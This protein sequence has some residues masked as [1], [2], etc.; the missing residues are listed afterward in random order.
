MIRL[1]YQ[2]LKRSLTILKMDTILFIPCLFFYLL[3]SMNVISEFF[4]NHVILMGLVQWIVPLVII[5]PILMMSSAQIIKKSF[6]YGSCFQT[7]RTLISSFIF[8]TALHQPWYI[9]GAFKLSLLDIEQFKTLQTFPSNQLFE[10]MGAII[11]G[12]VIAVITFVIPLINPM[13]KV[14]FGIRF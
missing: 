12:L 10:I 8:V 1:F 4:K 11:L 3:L 2:I 14:V 13:I 7:I 6:R 5:Q 9:F